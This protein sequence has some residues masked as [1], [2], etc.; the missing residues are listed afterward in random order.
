MRGRS[1]PRGSNVRMPCLICLEDIEEGRAFR[2]RARKC[3]HEMCRSCVTAF[4]HTQLDSNRKIGCPEPSCRRWFVAADIRDVLGDEAM[5]R[6]LEERR[7]GIPVCSEG[8]ERV[9]GAGG[10][11]AVTWLC[12]RC[13]WYVTRI[14]GCHKVECICGNKFCFK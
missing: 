7:G 10:D 9:E 8:A 13:M 6:L 12:L 4:V 14:D 2:Q 5:D 1:L 3:G 11:T